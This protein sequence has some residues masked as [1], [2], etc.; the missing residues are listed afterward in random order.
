MSDY[1]IVD[2]E[3][4][5]EV[6]CMNCGVMV[7]ERREYQGEPILRTLSNYALNAELFLEEDGKP[8]SVASPAIC[9][10]CNTKGID[11]DKVMKAILKGWEIEMRDMAKMQKKDIDKVLKKYEKVKINKLNKEK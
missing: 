4:I 9:K 5:K 6:H 1:L 3:G 8:H 7:R 10:D 2:A 11:A